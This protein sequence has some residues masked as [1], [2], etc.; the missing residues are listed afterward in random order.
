M[1]TLLLAAAAIA[2]ISCSRHDSSS[3][4]KPAQLAQA[5]A[6]AG[7]QP[8]AAEMPGAPV[9]PGAQPAPNESPDGYGAALPNSAPVVPPAQPDSAPT[10]SV[11]PAPRSSLPQERFSTVIPAGTPVRVRMEQTIGTGRNRPGDRFEASLISP[12][13]V[14]GNIIVPK[15]TLFEGHVSEA[16]PSG[17]LKGRAV[18]GVELDSFSLNGVRYRVVTAADSR[19]SGRHRK[20][21]LILIGGGSG[22]GATLGAIAGGPAGALIGAGAGAGA[23][24]AGAF[25]TG[26]KNVSL[27]VETALTFRLRRSVEIR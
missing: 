16:R 13:V 2:M 15:G 1:R 22:L 3:Q 20:R 11:A 5:Q 27:P 4:T 6:P 9:Q 18:L 12:I 25:F 14:G 10:A 7:A 24:T 8:A 19:V 26:R 23:G 17:R 21:N